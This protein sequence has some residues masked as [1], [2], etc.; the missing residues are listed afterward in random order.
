[1]LN[2]YV[3]ISAGVETMTERARATLAAVGYLICQRTSHVMVRARSGLLRNIR[4][5]KI[6]RPGG[7][8]CEAIVCQ[9][10]GSAA[11]RSPLRAP[12]RDPPD[13]QAVARVSPSILQAVSWNWCPSVQP[14]GATSSGPDWD[15][16]FASAGLDQSRFTDGPPRQVPPV[17][18]A[19]S[20]G[21]TERWMMAGLHMSMRRGTPAVPCSSRS[22]VPPTTFGTVP[23]PRHPATALSNPS[24]LDLVS[25]TAIT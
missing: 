19:Q 12:R 10:L 2:A 11:M 7:R 16:L 8:C 13:G 3:P 24:A 25:L 23:S 18:A 6:R 14:A 15:P 9:P 1:M 4:D 20:L 17:F 21:R 22:I 5:M